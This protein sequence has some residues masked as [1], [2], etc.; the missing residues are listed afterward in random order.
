MNEPREGP[1]RKTPR[2]K[3]VRIAAGE[4]IRVGNITIKSAA[5]I[6]ID[7]YCLE[8]YERLPPVERHA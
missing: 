3:R 2:A 7:I 5:A 1:R 4:A 6:E 8:Q